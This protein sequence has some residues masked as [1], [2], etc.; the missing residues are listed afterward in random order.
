MNSPTMTPIIAKVM[1]ILSPCEHMRHGGRKAHLGI[2]AGFVG[3]Y[4]FAEPQQIS[5]D[6]HQPGQRRHHHWKERNKDRKGNARRAADA[7]PDD[8]QRRQR[9]LRDQLEQHDVWIKGIS[10]QARL[11]DEHCNE[12]SQYH[13]DQKAGDRLDRCRNGLTEQKRQRFH[14]PVGNRGRCRQ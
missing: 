6:G 4:R 11:A 8:E 1:A 5:V 12:N 10:Y 13:R 7:K 14:Q 9:D 2:N 3:A